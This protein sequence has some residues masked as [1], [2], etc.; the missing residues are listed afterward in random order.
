[1]VV[2]FNLFWNADWEM[3]IELQGHISSKQLNL[4]P[5]YTNMFS[6]N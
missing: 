5:N 1:M 2:F 6:N 4:N 3:Y